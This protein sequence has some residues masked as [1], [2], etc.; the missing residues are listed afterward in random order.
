MKHVV[1]DRFGPPA[2]VVKC[3][4]TEDPGAPGEWEVAVDISAAAVNPSDISML[5]GQYGTL[6]SRLPATIG[7]E[8]S[9]R[10][11]SVG[12]SVTNLSVGDRV[13]VVANDNWQQRRNVQFSLVHKVP[14]ELDDLQA[15]MVKTNSAC[16]Y[17]MLKRAEDIEPDDFI[18]QSAPLSAV[19]RMVI[20]MAKAMGYRTVNIV[21]RPEA[22]NE[23]LDLGGDIALV[24]G[25]DIG[26]RVRKAT[27]DAPILLG[28]DAVAG[29]TTGRLADCLD[30][31]ASLI[32]YGML[33]GEPVQLRP[34]H[35]IFKDIRLEGFW[36]SKVL[37]RM[38]QKDRKALFDDCL[39]LMVQHG[40]RNEV[41]KTFPLEDISSAIEYSE[42]PERR[43][44]VLLLPNGPIA[45]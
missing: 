26:E 6:P 14:D 20:G 17:M 5:R 1:F 8:A 31:G 44:K 45:A 7:L 4:D 43:G 25:E 18:V 29:Q 13:I 19:G 24:D 36:L 15:A 41:G 40:L 11:A 33:S 32:S 2:R 22:V 28:L 23:V 35:T 39:D 30:T 12:S 10:V 42:T 9:G 3:V 21:R 16:A 37:N 38:S 34:D 27:N